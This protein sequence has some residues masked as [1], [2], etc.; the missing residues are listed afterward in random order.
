MPSKLIAPAP[1]PPAVVVTVLGQKLSS[2]WITQLGFRRAGLLIA[3]VMILALGVAANALLVSGRATELPGVVVGPAAATIQDNERQ[4]VEAE[5]I[6]LS[7]TGFHPK[8][9]TRRRG[10]FLLAVS[11]RSGLEEVVVRLDRVGADRIH[12]LRVSSK[13]RSWQRMVNLQPGQYVLSE[14]SHSEWI[15]QITIT[16]E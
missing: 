4:R 16:A 1:C 12:E 8:E 14:A 13:R 3:V 9:I 7:P 15:C 5:S 2:N 10:P 11:N 6:T